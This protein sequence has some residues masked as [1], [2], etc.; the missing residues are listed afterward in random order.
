MGRCEPIG[1]VR[2]PGFLEAEIREAPGREDELAPETQQVLV[3]AK[4][5][6]K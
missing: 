5:F 6:K 3:L 4:L 1:E 2:V